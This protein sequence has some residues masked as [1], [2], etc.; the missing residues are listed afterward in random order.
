MN[1]TQKAKEFARDWHVAKFHERT[2]ETRYLYKSMILYMRSALH[3]DGCPI[4][5]M[6]DGWIIEVFNKRYPKRAQ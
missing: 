2:T 6:N 1:H 5:G 3:E 4:H